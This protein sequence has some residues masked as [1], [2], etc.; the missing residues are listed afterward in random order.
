MLLDTLYLNNYG[1]VTSAFLLSLIPAAMT[2]LGGLL[3]MIGKIGKDKYLDAG[4]GFSAGIMLVASFTSL[5]I[6]AIDLGGM[7]ITTLG[8]LT[9]ILIIVLLD[10]GLPHEHFIKGQE[11]SDAILR[12]L[13][14]IWLVI[15]AILIHNIPEG[16]AVGASVVQSM[17][18]GLVMS[19]AI[20]FQDLP[21]GFAVVYPLVMINK[22]LLLPLS[23]CILSGFSETIMASLTALIASHTVS[24]LPF[25]LSLASGAMIY[26]V[27][28]EILPE[29]HRKGH[30]WLSSLGF[31]AGFLVMLW[32][33]FMFR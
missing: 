19:L 20:G 3:G 14:K 21:E 31:I 1:P 10:R 2:S 23:V 8:F 7:R 6:P 11:G 4:L 26:V 32:L 15:I 12:R 17:E 9:G 30:E 18:N 28:H 22:K 29:T 25:T 33:D 5:L 27:S 13:R 16:M 24:F